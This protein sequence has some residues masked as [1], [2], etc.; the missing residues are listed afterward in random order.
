MSRE[1][2]AAQEPR[3]YRF[4]AQGAD[5][6]TRFTHATAAEEELILEEIMQRSESFRQ[7][8][9]NPLGSD[10]LLWCVPCGQPSRPEYPADPNGTHSVERLCLPRRSGGYA[11]ARA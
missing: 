3:R 11:A 2:F 8:P 6:R 10:A 4:E 5:G 9:S 1:P 7:Q